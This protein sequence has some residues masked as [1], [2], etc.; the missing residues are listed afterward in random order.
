MKVRKQYYI[1]SSKEKKIRKEWK[2]KEK[3]KNERFT[4]RKKKERKEIDISK[5]NTQEKVRK[6]GTFSIFL[7]RK[8][9]RKFP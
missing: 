6:V 7:L 8:N 1:E 3:E 2:F 4:E 5:M 9:E